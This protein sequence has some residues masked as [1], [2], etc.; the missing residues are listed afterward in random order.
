M[1]WDF[2]FVERCLIAGRSLF[3]YVGKILWPDPLIFFYERWTIDSAVW[4]QYLFP[5]GVVLVLAG[6]IGMHKRWGKGLPI[7][8][9]IF[10]GTLLPALGFFN[11]YPHR[12]SFVA[13][14]FQY[15]AIPAF[16]TLVV[17]SIATG[18]KRLGVDKPS[19]MI[20]ATVAILA[21]CIFISNKRCSAYKDQE[22]LWLD[23]IEQNPSCWAAY[24]NR[25][26]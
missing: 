18:L 19:P 7:A 10:C 4:W 2:S 3:F 9:M 14:H 5:L 12:Y 17:A 11:V 20:A 6:T 25:G 22:T 26:L 16:I 1:E 23:T 15:L 13:D 8:L 21:T 24:N